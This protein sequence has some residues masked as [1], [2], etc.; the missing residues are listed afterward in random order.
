[1]IDLIGMDIY[2]AKWKTSTPS[3]SELLDWT[4][5]FYKRIADFAALHSK[6]VCL[7]EWGNWTPGSGTDA[8]SRG[9]GDFPEYI[10]QTMD[11][12]AAVNAV[13]A[14]YYNVKDPANTNIEIE[15]DTPLSYQVYLQ[16]TGYVPPSTNVFRDTFTDT[17]GVLLGSHAPET[18]TGWQRHPSAT[19]ASEAISSTG[20]SRANNV[21]PALW[22]AL[23]APASADYSVEADILF[24]SLPSGTTIAING[25]QSDTAATFYSARYSNVSGKWF[26]TKTVNGVQTSLPNSVVQVVAAGE[27]PRVTLKFV[28]STI[29]LFLDGTQL[30]T[31]TDTDITAAG[32]GGFQRTGSSATG[33]AT[34]YQID[35]FVVHA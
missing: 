11:W 32:Y 23:G 13:Y 18:G 25:R 21:Q 10:T 35:N 24:K 27:T 7:P 9:R 30:I 31:V 5:A 6:P 1:V 34:G 20:T 29:T 16:R 14:V 3:A 22:T 4:A 8:N 17:A 28:G 19:S 2:A 26:I 12:L 15:A 33:E